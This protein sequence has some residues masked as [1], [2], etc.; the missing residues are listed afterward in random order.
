MCILH[1]TII[2]RCK[3]DTKPSKAPNQSQNENRRHRIRNRIPRGP[4]ANRRRPHPRHSNRTHERH[5]THRTPSSTAESRNLQEL[6]PETVGGKV[7]QHSKRAGRG[8]HRTR[9]KRLPLRP[10]RS[11]PRIGRFGQRQRA[12]TYRK[13]TSVSVRPEKTSNISHQISMKHNFFGIDD[14]KLQV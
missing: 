8:A 6:N 1:N 7:V 13:T 14:S 11:G 10:H 2:N 5:P 12:Y 9:Q 4:T 3:L